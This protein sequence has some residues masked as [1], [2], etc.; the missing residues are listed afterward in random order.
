MTPRLAG[1]AASFLLGAAAAAQGVAIR[2][3]PLA[4]V[5]MTSKDLLTTVSNVRVLSS[6]KLLVLDLNGRKLVLVERDLQSWKVVAD[7]TPATGSAFN[8]R[9]AGLIAYKGDSSL[10][11]DPTALTMLVVTPE[12]AIGRVMAIPRPRDARSLIGGSSGTPA[13][14]AAGRLV[15]LG[16]TT[17][18]P[19]PKCNPD[20]T[21]EV[22]VFPDSAPLLRVDLASRVLD[23]VAIVRTQRQLFRFDLA[24][25]S[26]STMFD[27]L[28][29]SDDWVVTPAGKIAVVRGSDYHVDWITPGAPAVSAQ[30]LPYDWKR[31]D[32]ATKQWFIDSTKA[33]VGKLRADAVIQVVE[34][35]QTSM[36]GG[37]YGPPC[38]NTVMPTPPEGAR[39]APGSS[40]GAEGRGMASP[41]ANRPRLPPIY[42]AGPS[43]MPDYIPPFRAGAAR[44]DWEGNIWIR[45]SIS[46]GGGPVYDVINDKGALI[47]R[48]IIPAGR[49]I[50]GF[51][52]GGAI[53]MGVRDGDGTRLEL[54]HWKRTT[55]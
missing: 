13:F 42:I 50:S 28:P 22:P 52:S 12:G 54:A 16:S 41:N 40:A 45:T 31:L 15:F 21:K 35:R 51:G 27:P 1:L 19:N 3:H 36:F 5:E 26:M 4:A 11:V 33:Y 24:P 55:P 6:G 8:G 7:T 10:F 25:P 32:D 37:F 17:S 44:A 9:T 48:L 34:D 14:D 23:T 29:L 18:A 49:V 20:G 46:M 53:Y 38:P 2:P 43:Y 47:D 30:K 39:V